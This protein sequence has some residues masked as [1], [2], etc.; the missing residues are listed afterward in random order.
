M[1]GARSAE[2]GSGT[3]L[4]LAVISLGLVLLA[5]LALLAGVMRSRAQA[6]SGADLA[7]IAAAG[8]LHRNPG[9]SPCATAAQVSAASGTDLAACRIDGEFVEVTVMSRSL[10]GRATASARAGPASGDRAVS[11]N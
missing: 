4:A 3:V 10:A 8:V 7:A 1:S 2:R 6:Q 9:T 11:G 5:F